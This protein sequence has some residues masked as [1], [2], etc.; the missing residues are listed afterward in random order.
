MT[1]TE[2][3][4]KMSKRSLVLHDSLAFLFLLGVTAVLFA[5]TLF[6]FR[7]FSAHRAQI[8]RQAGEDG[9]IALSK[10]RPHE[11]IADLRT[12][13]SYAP[14][15]RSYEL[16]LAQALGDDG[17]IEEADNYF[18]N[19]WE[20]QPGDG[21][22]NLQLARLARQLHKP[23]DANNY[24][25][26]AIYG[27]WNGDGVARRREVRVEL[28]NFLIEQDQPSLA[29]NVLLV[30]ASNA[31]SDPALSLSFGDDLLRA[32]DPTDAM[33]Q[34]Q[35]AISESPRNAIAYE[36]AGQLAYA[37]GDYAHARDYLEKALRESAGVLG[38]SAEPES[39]T[40]AMLRNA[41]RLLVLDPRLATTRSDRVTR[42]LNNRATAR[43]RL[44]ACMAQLTTPQL[45]F[46]TLKSRW[47]ASASNSTR[48]ALMRD[49]SNQ[50]VNRSLINDTETETARFCGAPR[51]D[52]ALLL[53]LAKRA[54]N[55]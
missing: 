52:D 54:T 35:K 53:L 32:N 30:A 19:L 20:S 1:T 5:V 38:V 6:L 16:L 11:A 25:R 7:S 3:Q 47:T 28:A 49:D 31:P 46:D 45:S 10:H 21:F 40:T 22:I 4:L 26:A 18:L 9:R 24:Y 27:S 43:K 23:Q 13:L 29:Q 36:K 17:H 33:K 50:D 15:E 42:I 44:D 48:S 51:G 14:N 12:A 34:Y 39:D 8:A 2:T 41:E 37:T 55:Q